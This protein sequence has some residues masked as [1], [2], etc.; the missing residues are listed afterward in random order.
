MSSSVALKRK[1][2]TISE[3]KEIVSSMKAF[4]NFNLQTAKKSLN[5]LH[6][7]QN[8]IEDAFGDI[9]TLFPDLGKVNNSKVRGTIYV[10]FL[11]EEGLCGFFNED[12]LNFFNSLSNLDDT[13]IVIGTKGAQEIK[14]KNIICKYFLKG[15]SNVEAIELKAIELSSQLIEIFEKEH[16]CKLILIHAELKK[17]EYKIV[18][19]KVLPLDFSEFHKKFI[20]QE[21]LLYLKDEEILH[22]LIK[23]HLYISIYRA[24]IESVASE[25][26]A[27]LNAMIYADNAIK[28]NEKLLTQK[29]NTQRQKE[30]TD[31]LL[32]IVNAYRSIVHND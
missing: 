17:G 14:S 9:I 23:E 24:F 19:K 18:K 4:A 12:I 13:T 20:Q 5:N 10:L 3:I 7:Y 31:E 25:N 26:Q 32:D 30:I 21:P 15:A 2:H 28:E 6:L 8:N 29:L 11:S 22:A 1:L 27:R 16:F